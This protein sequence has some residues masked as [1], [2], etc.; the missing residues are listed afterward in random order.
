M[1]KSLPAGYA[2]L[3]FAALLLFSA[4][5]ALAQ[6]QF[7]DL[8]NFFSLPK[9]YVVGYTK[10]APV[11]DGDIT[12]AAWQQAKW[13]DDFVDIEGNLKP[14]PPL[15]TN[16]KMLWDDTC[17]YIAAQVSDPNVW[18][19]LK[20]HDD[21]VF[22]DN[23]VEVFINPNNTTHQY[24]EIECNA[25]NTIF[26]LFLNK[27]YR[28]LGLPMSAWNVNG[29]RSAVKVQGT[30]NDPLDI[31]KGWTMEMAIPFKAISLGNRTQVPREGTLWRINFSRV[32]WDT[33]TVN[34]KY[35][36]LKDANGRNLPEHNWVW[37]PQGVVNMHYPERWGYLQF[38]KNAASD[39]KFATPYAEL[40]KQYLWL[41][42]Y[43][44]KALI[45]RHNA[46]GLTLKELDIDAKV[47]INGNSN[48][49]KMEASPHQFMAFI[50]DSKNNITYTIDQDG[51]VT[52]L[53][54]PTL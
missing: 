39:A 26:D 4:T 11:I 52:I 23:D 36:K 28:N 24:Y 45:N 38:T 29:M 18:A 25:V 7:K 31:D 2:K 9:S 5:A 15:K 1:Y 30:L 48:L 8:E 16:I 10:T 42:Y 41:A 12:D 22:Q 19:Y 49:L 53:A 44:Q 54:P 17:L 37:S 20:K 6:P 47:T 50:T 51:F 32:E 33:K 21:I 14:N 35:E 27:P 13:T 34:G 46:Y 40:Q 43:R 3:I